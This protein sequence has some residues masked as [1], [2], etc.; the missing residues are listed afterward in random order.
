MAK[1]WLVLMSVLA[2]TIGACSGGGGGSPSPKASAAG[3]AAPAATGTPKASATTSPVTT[4]AVT[5]A[6]SP[7]GG[8]PSATSNTSVSG[9]LRM[10]G[11]SAAGS[12]EADLLQTVLDKFQDKFPN[13]TVTFEPLAE[14]YEALMLNKLGVAGEAPD[15][16]YMGQNIAPDWIDQGVIQALDELPQFAGFDTS[17]FYPGYLSPFQ[18]D[19]HT[20]GFPKDSSVLGMQTNDEMLTTATVEIPATVADLE[21]AANTIKTAAIEGMDAPMCFSNEW[22]R[23]GAFIE[24]NGGGMLNEDGTAAAIDSPESKEAIDWYLRMIREDLAATPADMGVD[25]CGQAMSE[26]RV[27]FA[28]EGNWIGSAMKENAPDLAYTVSPIPS[29]TEQATLSFTVSYA[30]SPHSENKDAAWE[31]IAYL[32]GPEGM[33][34]W[35]NGGLVLPARSDV[36]VEDPDLAK[37]SPFAEFAHPGEGVTPGWFAVSDAFKS[38]LLSAAQGDGTADDVVDATLPVLEAALAGE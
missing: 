12:V 24:A 10:G 26:E 11:W 9:D 15:L 5:P 28:F 8:S 31:L 23:A 16:F 1:R 7:A 22:Q 3:S 4:P 27:A 18:R 29:G 19:G 33:Q 37:Y 20:Y 25:W 2:L 32:T 13:V 34:E 6:G 21:A 14:S 36:T 38:A 30:M 35:V 17:A